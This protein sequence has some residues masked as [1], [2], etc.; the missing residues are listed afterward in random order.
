MLLFD[1][2]S[3]LFVPDEPV[4]LQ[5][6]GSAVEM[7]FR[8]S[9]MHRAEKGYVL[10][11]QMELLCSVEQTCA[12]LERCRTLSLSA[13]GHKNTLFAGESRFAVTAKSIASY[14]N[15]FARDACQGSAAL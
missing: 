12:G 7:E 14:H 3:S 6:H 2:A 11:G 13:I 15:S 9:M 5:E 8:E 4:R 1:T 10:P